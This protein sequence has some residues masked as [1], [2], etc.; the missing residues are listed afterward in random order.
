VDHARGGVVVLCK[1]CEAV[2]GE[3]KCVVFLL[4]SVV[5]LRD[6]VRSTGYAICLGLGIYVESVIWDLGSYGSLM[7]FWVHMV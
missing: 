2:I 7:W 4:L 3:L 1:T 6:G 5:N